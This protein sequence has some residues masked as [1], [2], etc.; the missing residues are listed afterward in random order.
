[1][2]HALYVERIALVHGLAIMLH[3]DFIKWKH[4][5]RYGPFVPGIH[6]SPVYSPQKG[7]WRGAL[8]FSLICVWINGWVNN[9]GTGNLR[10]H[11]AH[12]DVIVMITVWSGTSSTD[13]K[14]YNSSNFDPAYGLTISTLCANDQGKLYHEN[15]TSTY[16]GGSHNPRYR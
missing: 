15:L 1:M 4:F 12:Y 7:Q 10:R 3:D 9:R 16:V 5:P 13:L 11:R 14:K 6:Q 2:L 8:M